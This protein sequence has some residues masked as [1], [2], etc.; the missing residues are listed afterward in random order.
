M[1]EQ[2]RLQTYTAPADPVLEIAGLMKKL[3]GGPAI[4]FSDVKGYDTPVVGNMLS[5]RENVEAAF[6]ADFR[7]IRTFV[8]RALGNPQTPVVVSRA[9][10]QEKVHTKEFDIG[11]MLPALQHTAADNGR[12]ITAGVVIVKDPEIGRAHV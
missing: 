8:G 7:S 11:K 12:F 2:G 10:A 5:C 1:A 4:L 3:D 6:G 9:P